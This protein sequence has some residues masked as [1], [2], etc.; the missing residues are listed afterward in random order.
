METRYRILEPNE[1]IQEGDEWNNGVPVKAAIGDVVEECDVGLFRRPIPPVDPLVTELVDA[2]EAMIS[3]YKAMEH[4][5]E[6]KH[7]G[8]VNHPQR[9]IKHASTILSKARAT[10]KTYETVDGK[11]VRHG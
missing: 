7:L 6:I 3:T 11:A 5:V 8:C 2:L 9:V 1:V 4:V 10:L